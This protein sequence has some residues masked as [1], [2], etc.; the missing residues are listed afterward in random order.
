MAEPDRKR[1]RRDSPDF[2]DSSSDLESEDVYIQADINPVSLQ[3]LYEDHDSYHIIHK[4]VHGRFRVIHKLGHGR[5]ST[6]WLCRDL[7]GEKPRF[8]AL[9]IS[10]ACSHGEDCPATQTGDWNWMQGYAGKL[11][12]WAD[13]VCLPVR[14]F[15]IESP[16]GFHHCTVY[17]VLGPKLTL[18][19][20][21]ASDADRFLRAQGICR[22]L[23]R[24]VAW[25]HENWFRHGSE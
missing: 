5:N 6:V 12:D 11:R 24:S 4:L 23:I 22:D 9:K 17:P 1:T 10:A 18:W 2:D 16:N 13:T 25:L 19:Y 14:R 21:P 7:R 8:N 20:S 15:N 3:E